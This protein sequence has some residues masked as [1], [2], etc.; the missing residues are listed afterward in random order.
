MGVPSNVGWKS[1][2]LDRLT[3][4]TESTQPNRPVICEYEPSGRWLWTKWNGTVLK[5]TWKSVVLAMM[6]SLGID[7]FVQRGAS[8]RPY[9]R[10]TWSLLDVPENNAWI[11]RLA[12][13]KKLWEYQLTLATFILTFFLSQAFQYWQKVYNT[14]RMIQGRVND[15]CMLLNMGAARGTDEHNHGMVTPESSKHS[16]GA[17]KVNG[18]S[19]VNGA[20][21][22]MNGTAAPPQRQLVARS[23]ASTIPKGSRGFSDKAHALVL[24]CTRLIRMS[25]VFFWAATKTASNGLSDNTEY[26][27]DSANCPLPVDASDIGVGPVLLSPYGLRAMVS[28]GALTKEEK[29]ALQGTG[30][31]PSQYAYVLLVWVGIHCME[32]FRNGSLRGGP[33]FEE[34]IFRQLASLRASMFD[35][36]DFRAG[37]MP[38][39]YVQLVQ[40]LVDSL[41]WISPFALYSELGILSVPLTGLLALFFRGLLNLSKSFLDPFGVEGFDQQCIRVDVLVSELN[42]GASKRWNYAAG[43]VPRAPSSSPSAVENAAAAAAATA[44]FLSGPEGSAPWLT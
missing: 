18:A 25:H 8:L 12:G 33:G 16:N 43:F 17:A 6:L 14:V 15:F 29:E 40:V 2:R 41:V 30:L 39:A 35:I 5:A 37:R 31:P 32:G 3:D 28:S 34:N 10:P 27:Q 26:L 11:L 44:G 23:N 22:D 20:A 4:W 13:I 9:L 19:K 24:L 21:K 36:D 1:G 42:F 38:V 7:F